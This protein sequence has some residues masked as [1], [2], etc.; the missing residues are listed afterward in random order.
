VADR[1]GAARGRRD[2]RVRAFRG[3]P[4]GRGLSGA[5]AA[6]L[7]AALVFALLASLYSLSTPLWEAPDEPGHFAYAEHLLRARA[8][9]V[10]SRA[11][12]S[13]AHQPPLYY[14]LAALAMAP[15]DLADPT[16]Q[17]RLN[18]RFIWAG[19]SEVNAGV[20]GT[21][22]TFPWRGRAL[23]LRLGRFVSVLLGAGTAL[24][25]VLAARR[26]FPE[27]A[28]VALVA[29][30][31]VALNPQVLFLHGVL[32]NDALATLAGAGALWATLRALE[33]P[34]AWRRWAVVGL[35]IGIGLLAKTTVAAAG[36]AAALLLVL[37]AWRCRSGDLLVRGA[38]ALALP[39]FLLAAPWL[40]R[41]A[42]L[43]GDPLGQ[44]VYREVW[45]VNVRAAP[46]TAADLAEFARL[47]FRSFWGVFGWMNVF[48][49][50][51]LYAAALALTLLGLAAALPDWR[52]L[53]APALFV[54]A[55]LGVMLAV[56]VECNASCYQGRYLFPAL[57]PI[58]LLLAAGLGRDRRV[59]A[60]VTVAL[61]AAALWVPLR[62]IAPAY[63][64]V[65]LTSLEA[66]GLPRNADGA[67]GG[68][69][70]LLGYRVDG[71]VVT[72]YW[73][74][75]RTPDFDYSAFVHVLDAGGQIAAQK[76]H[77]PGEA[78]GHPPTAWT[79]GDV[80]AD[81]HDVGAPVG[82]RRLRV[83]LYDWR[84]GR[85]LGEPVV[86]PAGP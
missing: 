20:H 58:A 33:A 71:G 80:V 14:A 75:A 78:A 73:R 36:V 26:L 44:A 35:W 60:A 43:Y 74:A 55:Q 38:A 79:P 52:R 82:A 32:N 3:R 37:V 54:A 72:L 65:P 31:L 69:L 21:A 15:A 70:E 7:G 17:F 51:W 19:G 48:L 50:G 13:A 64:I 29:G 56:L 34:C 12:P 41:N 81:S 47:G 6:P 18:P 61:A 53:G 24:L 46:L 16:G 49:P 86:L 8:L 10:Q 5:A 45:A 66:R 25:T 23:A 57:A 76:D 1:R 2:R 84:D 9:P 11:A 27:R 85:Q 28:G 59:A 22:E 62:V 4:R 39:T 63:P 68:Q 67:F 83:G 42:A 30:A 77:A 40:V